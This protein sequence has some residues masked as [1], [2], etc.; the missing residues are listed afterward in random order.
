MVALDGITGNLAWQWAVPSNV[1]IEHV[2]FWGDSVALLLHGTPVINPFNGI[3][4]FPTEVMVL[5]AA[6][7]TPR[8]SVNTTFLLP[9][10]QAD[11][12]SYSVEYMV[13]GEGV[14]VFSRGSKLAAMDSKDGNVLWRQSVSL[15]GSVGTGQGANI[16]HMIFIP[17]E[18]GE[19]EEYVPARLLVNA[20][21]WSFQR[22]ALL[23]FN[24]TNITGGSRS[25]L[26]SLLSTLSCSF[27]RTAVTSV[28]IGFNFCI[29]EHLLLIC[30]WSTP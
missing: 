24:Q 28:C 9:Q 30:T 19:Q 16:T 21:N 17:E 8:W 13:A 4:T 2:S 5:D 14:V 29:G 15:E 26:L 1:T 10:T 3:P 27:V 18:P 6:A 7:G 11:L 22:F 20:N 12:A 23:Q 25:A